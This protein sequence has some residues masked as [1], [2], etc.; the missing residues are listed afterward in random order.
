M[1]RS[2][3]WFRTGKIIEI[4]RL[5]NIAKKLQNPDLPLKMVIKQK[6]MDQAMKEQFRKLLDMKTGFLDMTDLFTKEPESVLVQRL[7]DPVPQIRLEAIKAIAKRR[8]H[9]EREIMLLLTDPIPQVRQ[10][11]REAMIVLSRGNDFGPSPTASQKEQLQAHEQW[12]T[13]LEMQQPLA[14]VAQARAP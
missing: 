6:D 8:L 5:D 13:W 3:K 4:Q 11:A 7:Q 10:A 2:S 9:R 1:Q 14:G 12:Q